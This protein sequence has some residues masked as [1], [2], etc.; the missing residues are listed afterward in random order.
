MIW[1]LSQIR[2]R[3][4]RVSGG[5]ARMGVCTLLVQGVSPLNTAEADW[6]CT[7]G[8]CRLLPVA[9]GRTRS[10]KGRWALVGLRSRG[11]CSSLWNQNI[12]TVFTVRR[13]CRFLL[14]VRVIGWVVGG[15]WWARRPTSK[16]VFDGLSLCICSLQR[17]IC[18]RLSLLLEGF[19]QHLLQNGT[20][21]S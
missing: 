8:I 14:F 2:A 3:S 20:R 4:C 21:S 19:T 18:S 16:A 9:G 13:G 11:R 7:V 15:G 10:F 5:H 17:C 12:L 1:P 6:S